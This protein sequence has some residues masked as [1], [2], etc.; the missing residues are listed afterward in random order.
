MLRA[1]GCIGG[2]GVEAGAQFLELQAKREKMTVEKLMIEKL[3]KNDDRK[4][5]DREKK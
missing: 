3:T 5:D 2:G 4:T 1:L